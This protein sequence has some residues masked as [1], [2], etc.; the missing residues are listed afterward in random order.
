MY[1][2][3]EVA[4]GASLPAPRLT[5]ST[6]IAKHA[7]TVTC[8]DNKGEGGTP[9]SHLPAWKHGVRSVTFVTSGGVVPSVDLASILVALTSLV[10]E[11]PEMSLVPEKS[12]I[13][14]K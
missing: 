6:I 14:N 1:V 11:G 5:M 13:E 9:V 4:S 2:N 10:A 7:S 12:P 3:C 8:T